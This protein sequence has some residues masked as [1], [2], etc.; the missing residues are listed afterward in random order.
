MAFQWYIVNA[1]SGYEK[2]VAQAIKEQ[3]AQK[4]LTNLIQDV[5]VPVEEVVEVRKGQKVNTERKFFPGYVLVKMELNDDTWHLVKSVPRVTGFLGGKGKPQAIP[6]GEVDRIFKQVQEGLEQP[7]HAVA[8]EAGESVK[9]IDGP[10]ES[11]VGVVEEVDDEKN[12]L[13]VAVS[14]FGRSTPVELE[15]IQVEKL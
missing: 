7:R 10:F 6:Q 5:V 13:K 8:F 14:I 15:F 12:R 2:K 9:I 3:A 4:G 11:F 1:F